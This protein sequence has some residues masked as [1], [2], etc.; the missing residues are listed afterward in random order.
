MNWFYAV[1]GNKRVSVLKYFDAYSF[2]GSVTR[3]VPR[4]D[5]SDPDI[6]IYYEFMEFYRKTGINAIWFSHEGS[7]K[8]LQQCLEDYNPD[9]SVVSN[10]YTSFVQGVYVPFRKAFHS[11]GGDRL[12]I[13]TGDALLEY[14]RVYGIPDPQNPGMEKNLSRLMK[15]LEHFGGDEPAPVSTKPS[16]LSEHKNIMASIS[17]LV[18]PSKKLKVAFAYR[19]TLEDSSW[20]YSHEIGRLHVNKVLGEQ[21]ETAYLENVPEGTRAYW[22]LRHLADSGYDVIFATSPGFINATLKAAL[23]FRNTRFFNCSE[24]HSL[25]N[26]TTYFGRI[27]EARFLA[28]IISGVSTTTDIL[29]FVGSYPVPGII[30]GINAFALGARLVNPRVRVKVAWTKKWSPGKDCED[31]GTRLIKERADIVSHINTPAVGEVSTKYGVY[32][33]TYSA[34][35]NTCVPAHHLACPIWNWGMFYERIIRMILNS[36]SNQVSGVFGGV[37]KGINFWW[38]LDSG[39][40]DFFYSKSKVPRDTG[41]LVDFMKRMIKSYEYNPFTGPIYDQNNEL[42]IPDNEVLSRRDILTM[43]WF[44]DA[45]E[46]P[47]EKVDGRKMF[48]DTLIGLVEGTD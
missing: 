1:E 3:L 32:S 43:D 6:R 5:E 41:R 34:D 13:T 21:V 39:I 26:V 25:K 11:D 44:V 42:R 28:G 36:F 33:M 27:Y 12:P 9:K 38:G 46:T 16:K 37:A 7:F 18:T 48:G 10:K 22:D 15:E 17:N 45:V 24:T 4:R 31:A 23:E 19:G 30:S 40:V 14:I 2:V 8:E 29:G 20:S 35:S 47:L